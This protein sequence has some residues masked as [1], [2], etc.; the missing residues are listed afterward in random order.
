[1]KRLDHRLILLLHR[2]LLEEFGGSP[3]V[4]DQGL[5]DAAIAAVDASF[6]GVERYVTVEEKAARLA[7]GLVSNHA[8]VDGN[9]RIGVHAMLVMLA[10]NGIEV[11]ATNDA[12]I[13]LGM[14]LAQGSRDSEGVL[15]WIHAHAVKPSRMKSPS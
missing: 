5:L 9:K 4:R 15:Q 3:G 1:M 7:F 2:Q 6:A 12:V 11:D 10:V 14:S 13:E 8:F